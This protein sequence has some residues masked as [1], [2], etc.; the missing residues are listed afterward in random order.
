MTWNYRLLNLDGSLHIIE[1]YYN[2]NGDIIGWILA[3]PRG[4]DLRDVRADLS[5]ML[6]ATYRDVLT[7]ADLPSEEQ[8]QENAAVTE[9]YGQLTLDEARAS[10]AL[11]GETQVIG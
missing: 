6:D 3:E 9:L 7:W 4:D 1:A 8:E 10:C 5:L 11:D 2:R